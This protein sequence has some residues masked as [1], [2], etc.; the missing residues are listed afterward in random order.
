M[1][2][3]NYYLIRG[4]C[5]SPNKAIC[6]GSSEMSRKSQEGK[7][8]H[9]QKILNHKSDRP[10]DIISTNHNGRKP[11]IASCKEIGT[12]IISSAHELFSFS[13]ISRDIFA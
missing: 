5:A 10:G 11:N 3:Q 8:F 2:C 7:V 12:K 4:S 1:E 6:L 13:G 9:L